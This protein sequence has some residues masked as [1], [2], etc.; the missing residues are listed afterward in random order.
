PCRHSCSHLVRS[1]PL[2]ALSVTRDRF[3]FANLEE[4]LPLPDLVA[5]QRDSFQWFLDQGL[6]ETFRDISPIE[7][8]TGQLRLELEF[9]PTD[10]DL[11]PPPKFSVEECKEKDM[12]Y[13]APIFVRARFMNATT[14]EI[15][16]QT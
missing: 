2:V 10:Q 8:F 6:A 3:S 1:D 7:D 13:A 4:V 15:K 14:G 16:G 11:R 5:V 12:T 9:D